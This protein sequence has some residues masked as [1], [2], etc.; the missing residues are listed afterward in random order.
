MFLN[1][2]DVAHEQPCLYVTFNLL[3]LR[4]FCV[5]MR[6]KHSQRSAT[7]SGFP[8]TSITVITVRTSFNASQPAF[9]TFVIGANEHLT[10]KWKRQMKQQ[11]SISCHC[12]TLMEVR[13]PSAEPEDVN[14]RSKM[15]PSNET[16]TVQTC[17]IHLFIWMVN[18][19]TKM[20]AVP[21]VTGSEV[22]SKISLDIL[23][24]G[25][26]LYK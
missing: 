16:A 18:L 23:S 5:P 12:D 10:H 3:F 17:L 21:T 7:L 14:I 25:L 20:M 11:S 8:D 24:R 13:P 22:R 15:S 1:S 4:W 19:R 26:L 9:R 2:D 6:Q